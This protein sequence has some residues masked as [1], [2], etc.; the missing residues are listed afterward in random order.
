MVELP[1]NLSPMFV[2]LKNT[3][4]EMLTFPMNVNV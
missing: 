1:T 3:I 2:V 4:E